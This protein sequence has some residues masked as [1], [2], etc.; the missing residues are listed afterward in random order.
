[1]AIQHYPVKCFVCV[2]NRITKEEIISIETQ[3]P[4][5]LLNYYE[6]QDP[7]TYTD[8]TYRSLIVYTKPPNWFDTV[9]DICNVI[10]T[11]VLGMMVA[12]S[13]V[14]LLTIIASKAP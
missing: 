10:T 3:N 5:L 1:M 9:K 8:Q 12:M 7:G 6:R 11:M 14:I 2:R 4:T 13:A